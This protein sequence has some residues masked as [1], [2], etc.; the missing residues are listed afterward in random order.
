MVT[1]NKKDSKQLIKQILKNNKSK[2]SKK[3]KEFA[4]QLVK[5]MDVFNPGL[6]TNDILKL[7][8][9]LWNK[10]YSNL[11]GARTDR[12]LSWEIDSDMN[13]L[14]KMTRIYLYKLNMNEK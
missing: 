9:I 6:D 2:P 3:D 7:M 14:E 13:L 8:Q 5:D 12:D 1:L 4:K 10:L 11:L